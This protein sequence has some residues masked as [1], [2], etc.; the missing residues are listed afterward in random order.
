MG[1][2][3]AAS[4]PRSA[5]YRARCEE[6]SFRELLKLFHRACE[7]TGRPGYEDRVPEKPPRPPPGLRNLR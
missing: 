6:K 3:Y 7:A 1:I 5:V 2:P 4:D